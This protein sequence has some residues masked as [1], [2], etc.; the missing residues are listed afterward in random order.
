MKVTVIPIV[1]SVLSLVNKRIVQGLGELEIRGQVETIQTKALSRSARILRRLAVTQTSERNHQLIQVG[2]C[3]VA[4]GSRIYRLL[5]CRGG[6]PP[7]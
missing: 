1:I 6:K 5:P 4:W 3:P 7:Q 2:N